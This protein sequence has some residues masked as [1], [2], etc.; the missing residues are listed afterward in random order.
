MAS[1]RELQRSFAAALRDPAVA[2][3]V[4]PPANLAIYRNNAGIT[5]RETLEH[6]FP[7]VRR[8]VGEDYFRQ[9]GAQYR[10]GFPSR[11]GDLHW[12]G[13]DF[14]GFLRAHLD[15]T[16][17][18]WLA[19]LAQLEWL[20]AESAVEAESPALGAEA[21]ASIPGDDLERLTFGL[22]TSLRL[23]SSPYPVFSVWEANQV[24]IAPPVDQSKGSERGMTL[25]RYGSTEVR[26]LPVAFFAFV[27]A[28][29]EGAT[30][31]NAMT[32]ASLDEH[33]LAQSLAMLFGEGLVCSLAVR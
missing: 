8:R 23:L 16:E 7:V 32:R 17:Y 4:L 27:S 18:A 14:A 25:Q 12:V 19:D 3:A 11:N 20:R 15:G 30:L 29:E 13:R 6:T 10:A 21:L 28:L 24:E 33:A 5:F 31:A 22:Q 1:L 2:C 26:R 9:L